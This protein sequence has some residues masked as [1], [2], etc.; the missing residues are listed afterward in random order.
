MTNV[1]LYLSIGVPLVFNSVLI[2]MLLMYMDRRFDAVNQR[3]DDMRG[4]WLAELHRVEQVL[5]ARLTHLEKEL[6]K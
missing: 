2:G 6:D 3:F 5:D 1:Q 4:L